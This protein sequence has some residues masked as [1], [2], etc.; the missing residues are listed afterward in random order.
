MNERL[1][2]WKEKN[3]ETSKHALFEFTR[4]FHSVFHLLTSSSY[5]G[6]TVVPLSVWSLINF[7]IFVEPSRLKWS[8][9]SEPLR[10][11]CKTHVNRLRYL[12]RVSVWETL[13]S[14]VSSVN[15]FSCVVKAVQNLSLFSICD[16]ALHMFLKPEDWHKLITSTIKLC[17]KMPTTWVSFMWSKG[18]PIKRRE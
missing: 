11:V 8:G 10:L 5:S 1:G 14:G 12:Q 15:M 2:K 16:N 13:N 4:H 18:L 7:R 6:Y 3:K 17:T 9:W